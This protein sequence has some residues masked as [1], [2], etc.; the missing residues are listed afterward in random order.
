MK[1]K[2][3]LFIFTII[4]GN[5]YAQYC[6][7]GPSSTFDS[8]V[9]S[10]VLTGAN[11]SINFTGCPGVSGVQDV[12]TQVADLL[13]NNPYTANIQFGTCGGNY[14]GAG[15][16]WI[17][18]NGDN[19]FQASESIGTWSGTPPTTLSAFSFTV[20]AA[21][22]IGST[23]MRVIQWEGG[24]TPL[25]PCGTYT[26]GS[27]MDFGITIVAGAPITCPAP[28]NLNV[29]NLQATS[30]SLNWT[31]GGSLAW[32]V[33][34]GPTGFTPGTGTLTATNPFNISGLSPQ[35]TYDWYVADLCAVGDTSFFVG[36]NTFTTP[37][38]AE[39]APWL[40][41][42]ETLPSTFN[43][44]INNCWSST[45]S[46]VA[47]AFR[48][49]ITATGTTPSSNT[50]A[51]VANSGSQY[52]FTEASNGGFGD[53]AELESPDVDIS[54][55][56]TPAI[57]FRYHM[58][59]ATINVLYIDAWDGSTWNPVDTITGEQHANQTDPWS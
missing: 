34:Y 30:A 41:D 19:I 33:E 28:T 18:F 57:I 24:T 3:L 58:K 27:A 55:L 9:Q 11:T 53:I 36:P 52:F 40:D 14:N 23:R 32:L 8:N 31:T 6:S 17:D 42:V 59:G 2:L 21:A 43:S 51:T 47:N 50:G 13:T 54:A 48:W 25:N 29:T 20:P 5:S 46:G 56:T 44:T 37:C 22:T 38:V 45:P 1:T 35:T 15:E 4:L 49:N 16:A 10:V 26:W 39:I 7:A 12:T